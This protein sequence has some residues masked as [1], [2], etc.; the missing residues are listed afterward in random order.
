MSSYNDDNR[1]LDGDEKRPK[2]IHLLMFI[3]LV[4]VILVIIIS[5]G[6]KKDNS[7]QTRKNTSNNSYLSS[8][9]LSNAKLSPSFTK[10]VYTY[11]AEAESDEVIVT[12]AVEDSSSRL[13]GCN[14]KVKLT[15]ESTKY[16][17]KVTNGYS[18]STYVINFKRNSTVDKKV[19]VSSVKSQDGK[20]YILTATVTPADTDAIYKW[21]KDNKEITNSNSSS[22]TVSESGKYYVS[23]TSKNNDKAVN[24]DEV[25]IT[26]KKEEIKDNKETSLVKNIFKINSIKGNS[27]SWT[28][29]VTL[30]VDATSTNG[31]DS[32]AYSFDG[33]NT[34]Q[35]SNKKTFTSNQTVVIVVRDKSGNTVK[36]TVVINKIDSTVPKVSISISSEKTSEIVLAAKVTPDKAPSGYK[37]QWYKNGTAISGATSSTYKATASGKYKVKVTTGSGASNT[38]SEYNYLT[39]Q[40]RCP[41]LSAMTKD[42]KTVVPRTWINED[43]YIKVTPP[44]GIVKYDIYVNKSGIYNMVSN[45]FIYYKTFD[46]A[47]AI[48]LS[49][50]GLR[51]IKIVSYDKA[52]NSYTCYSDIYFI[53]KK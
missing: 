14:E 3:I 49:A 10:N 20:S 1:Y 51:Y 45:E 43:V 50:G 52:G 16:E 44:T 42:K 41:R 31:L 17:I 8:L 39:V 23:V 40:E 11:E 6:M 48:K 38:S 15:S 35:Q 18:T 7:K 22:Y 46:K 36:E 26:I 21:F 13:D 32:H 5:C 33:G 12:C 25:E 24:S 29:S 27:S 9:K 47:V 4:V 19:S 30:T 37:Y 28:N 34:Y 2:L 53:N